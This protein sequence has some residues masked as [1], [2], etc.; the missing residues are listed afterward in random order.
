MRRSLLPLFGLC[1]LLTAGCQKTSYQ[2]TLTLSKGQSHLEVEFR[3]PKREQA[4]NF[5]VSA[6]EPVQI[7]VVLTDH[8]AE[9]IDAFLKGNKP[10]RVLATG[11]AAKEAKVEAKVPAEKS[12]VVLVRPEKPPEKDL[13]V[14]LKVEGR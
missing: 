11:D 10:R 7:V 5:I 6:E 13:E 14:N 3:G 4:M 8:K 12:W 2:N 1:L 9:A